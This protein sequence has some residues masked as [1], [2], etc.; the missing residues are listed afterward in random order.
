MNKALKFTI[1]TQTENKEVVLICHLNEKGVSLESSEV[2]RKIF[3]NNRPLFDRINLSTKILNGKV[4]RQEAIKSNTS[5]NRLATKT[6]MNHNFVETEIS[7]FTFNSDVLNRQRRIMDK[8]NR[9]FDFDPSTLKVNNSANVFDPQN[10]T[11]DDIQNSLLISE[12]EELLLFQN[13]SVRTFMIKDFLEDKKDIY[14]V[15]YRIEFNTDTK[16]KEYLDFVVKELD[17]SIKFLNSYSKSLQLPSRYDYVNSVFVKTYVDS[18]YESLGILDETSVNLGSSRIKSSEF[19]RAALAFYNASLMLT[20]NV[21]KSIYGKIMRAVLP[22]SLTSP[23]LVKSSISSFSNLYN[24]LTQEYG[25]STG[26]DKKNR[27]QKIHS[28]KK[29][30]QKYVHAF[31]ETIRLDQEALGY[32]VFTENQSGLNTMSANAYKNRFIEEQIKYYPS[33]DINDESSFMTKTEKKNFASLKNAPAFLTPSNLVM[34]KKRITTSR[35]MANI[36]IDDVREFRISKSSAAANLSRTR[37]PTPSKKTSLSKDVMSEFNL[38]VGPPK[39]TLLTR[40]AEENIDPLVDAKHYVG[41][42]SFFVTDNPASIL[43]TLKNIKNREDKKIF[44]IVSDVIPGRFL[45]Q[46][47]SIESINDLQISNKKSKFRG[48]VAERSIELSEIPPQIK[49]MMSSKFQTNPDVDPLQNKEARAIIDETQKNVFLIK[50]HVG[51]EKGEDG[52]AD[53]NMPI[54]MDMNDSSLDGKPVLAKA[55]NYEVPQLGIVKDKF[56]PT[57]YNN[58]LYIRN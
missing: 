23:E 48:L 19:G 21:E 35:G 52:F 58:L 29:I 37:F 11:L 1:E 56:M 36:N 30:K 42:G 43:R 50:A 17:E 51:F 2:A 34:G 41:F 55:Y 53:L 40:A 6:N 8:S 9:L 57:I 22:S 46:P 18:V 26:K 13:E 25:V 31:T 49:S 54:V 10:L 20:E 16:F 4:Y 24:L 32:N 28:S 44:A 45:R 33:L 27:K 15:S 7:N 12:V 3:S 14:E 38:T 39:K 5:L 47:N